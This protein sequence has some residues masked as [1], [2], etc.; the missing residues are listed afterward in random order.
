MR[1]AVEMSHLFLRNVL[2]SQA[3]CVDATLGHGKDAQFFLD[4]GCRQVIAFEIQEDVLLETVQRIGDSRLE[5]HC[6][7]HETMEE[8]L[9]QEVDAMIFNFGYCPHADSKIKTSWSTSLVAVQ[10]GLQMLR[11]KGRMALVFYPH[12]QGQMEAER[13]ESYLSTLDP[14][15]YWV[16]AFHPLNQRAVPY[17]VG[18]EKRKETSC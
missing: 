9:T 1:S 13:I 6:Q 17:L 10:K 16:I 4:Q 14:Q 2:H 7:G 8:V 15:D 5:A 18:V 12:A 11:K 3:V